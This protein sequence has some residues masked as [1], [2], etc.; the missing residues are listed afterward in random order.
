MSMAVLLIYITYFSK[1]ISEESSS[2]S[3]SVNAESYRS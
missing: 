2:G 3:D 1:P